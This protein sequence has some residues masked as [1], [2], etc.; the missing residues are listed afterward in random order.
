LTISTV[1][2]HWHGRERGGERQRPALLAARHLLDERHHAPADASPLQSGMHEHGMHLVWPEADR[3]DERL[4]V[5][6]GVYLAIGHAA[7]NLGGA[8]VTDQPRDD[9]RGIVGNVGLADRTLAEGGHGR[10][11]GLDGRTDYEIAQG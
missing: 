8:K 5:E 10:H 2:T 11:I 3:A 7:P 6:G 9:V 4:A 1:A